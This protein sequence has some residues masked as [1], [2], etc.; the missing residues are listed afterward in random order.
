MPDYEVE[1]VRGCEQQVL[2]E[3]GALSVGCA[4]GFLE[5]MNALGKRDPNIRDRCGLLD[6]QHEIY[7]IP[8]PDCKDHLMILSIDCKSAARPRAI[9]GILP[10]GST[11]CN[12]GA[13]Q[14]TRQFGLINPSWET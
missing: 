13:G 8:V 5:L 1:P 12:Q 2:K 10:V 11:V 3:Y 7:A 6:D 4:H 14:A 9:H